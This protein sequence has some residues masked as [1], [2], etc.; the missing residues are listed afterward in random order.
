VSAPGI[1]REPTF[2]SATFPRIEENTHRKTF[3]SGLLWRSWDK[4]RTPS[5]HDPSPQIHSIPIKST[6]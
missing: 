2:P 5:S 6:Y 4:L 1:P 3:M